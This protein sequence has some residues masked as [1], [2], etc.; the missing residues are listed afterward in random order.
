MLIGI[1]VTRDRGDPR[2]C[3]GGGIVSIGVVVAH[4]HGGG[5]IR[6][7]GQGGGDLQVNVSPGLCVTAIGAIDVHVIAV[8][9]MKGR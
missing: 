3:G 8:G 6:I 9:F 4:G 1:V 7:H 5:P 2:T